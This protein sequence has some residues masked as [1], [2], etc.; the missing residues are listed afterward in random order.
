MPPKKPNKSKRTFGA[1]ADQDLDDGLID[2][3]PGDPPP[4]GGPS[5][6]SSRNGANRPSNIMETKAWKKTSGGVKQMFE[7]YIEILR[8]EWTRMVR[9]DQEALIIRGSQILTIGS[10]ALALSFVYPLLPLFAR[11]FSVPVVLGF[12]WWFGTNIISSVL[13][14]RFDKYLNQEI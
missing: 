12:A 6:S 7:R 5:Y 14:G 2:A 4:G 11:V 10:A 3:S 9:R 1:G 8:N 13:I